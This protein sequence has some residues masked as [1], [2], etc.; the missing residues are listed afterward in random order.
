MLKTMSSLLQW[1]LD[2]VP[3]L[4][5]ETFSDCFLNAPWDGRWDLDS[6]RWREPVE[7]PFGQVR[8]SSAEERRACRQNAMEAAKV[9]RLRKPISNQSL[10]TQIAQ[11]GCCGM[12]NPPALECPN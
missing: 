10:L 2:V 6:P 8:G 3:E 4:H 11:D 12:A 7:G 1:V 5:R 9:G